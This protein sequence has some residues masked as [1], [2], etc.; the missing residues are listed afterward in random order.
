MSFGKE[1]NEV[2]YHLSEA[3]GCLYEIGDKYSGIRGY[4]GDLNSGIYQI[5]KKLEVAKAIF[6]LA[7]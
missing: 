3:I 6:E 2:I 4:C 7:Q 5:F 1:V